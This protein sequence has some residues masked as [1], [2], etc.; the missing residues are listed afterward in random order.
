[1][2]AVSSSPRESTRRMRAVVYHKA[3]H[4]WRAACG[5]AGITAR[6]VAGT[7][8]TGVTRWSLGRCNRPRRFFL[9]GTHLPIPSIEWIVVIVTGLTRCPD[10]VMHSLAIARQHRIVS[11]NR[12]GI[13][14]TAAARN[15]CPAYI[16]P[17]DD[18]SGCDLWGHHTEHQFSGLGRRVSGCDCF[19]E[20]RNAPR[21]TWIISGLP[22]PMAT[23]AQQRHQERT[24]GGWSSTTKI[25][26]MVVLPQSAK[27][28]AMVAS[29]ACGSI[30]RT[31]NRAA[32]NAKPRACSFGS[33]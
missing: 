12:S 7:S 31:I 16:R 8:I 24:V 30:G 26:A 28:A 18:R 29:S 22:Q 17:I 2:F 14:N 13:H 6:S 20:W 9:E 19:C 10:V 25:V 33:K 32:P 4:G 3:Y 11:G 23:V 5:R 21:R 15:R 27:Q 1:M